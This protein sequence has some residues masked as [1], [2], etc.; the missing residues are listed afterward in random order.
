MVRIICWCGSTTAC[1]STL[2]FLI[3]ALSVCFNSPP[4][5]I[6]LTILW[7]CAS[8]STIITIPSSISGIRALPIGLCNVARIDKPATIPSITVAIFDLTVFLMISYRM[9]PRYRPGGRWETLKYFF[10][11]SQL[12]PVS[13]ALL[14]T[15]QL[16]LLYVGFSFSLF[17]LLT[18][19]PSPMAG[20][21]F[22][23]LTIEFSNALKSTIL[24][25]Y[26]A[27]VLLE[28]AVFLNAMACRVFRLLRRHALEENT[29]FSFQLSNIHFH[30]I[31]PPT[32]FSNSEVSSND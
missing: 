12:A 32:G 16:Y 18:E 24:I 6:V 28:G 25:Q 11:G 19:N 21:L 23:I 14:R 3:R 5:K 13:R 1:L 7:L 26:R 30:R 2:L 4:S 27:V 20:L 9:L 10:T 31:S 17:H 8:L 22:C 15:G 29:G